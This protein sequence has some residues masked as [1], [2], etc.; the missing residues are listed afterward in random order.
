MK[1]LN[2]I[3][4]SMDISLSKLWEIVRIKEP[5]MLQF[6]RSQRVRYDL[7][8]EQQQQATLMWIRT[9]QRRRQSLLPESELEAP[10]P[11]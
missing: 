6:M 11:S 1:Q 3:T 5:G 10:P 9:R 2:G 7:A 4:N 8:T